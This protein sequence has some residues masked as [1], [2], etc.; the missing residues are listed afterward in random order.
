MSYNHRALESVACIP[1]LEAF[2]LGQRGAAGGQQRSY[3]GD[4]PHNIFNNLLG[5]GV[6]E[7]GKG[8]G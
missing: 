2:T 8:V 7:N 4:C 3:F 5:M 6:F 1:P